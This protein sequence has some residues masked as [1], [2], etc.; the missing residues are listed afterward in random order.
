[1][2]TPPTVKK[3]VNLVNFP[4]QVDRGS[5]SRDD[6]LSVPYPFHMTLN[7]EKLCGLPKFEVASP[8]N[9]KSYDYG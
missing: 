6:L 8:F 3:K 2:V 7:F 5:W 4:V 1:M 9:L